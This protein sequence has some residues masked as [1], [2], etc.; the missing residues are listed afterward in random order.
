MNPSMNNI[1]IAGVLS[2]FIKDTHYQEAPGLGILAKKTDSVDEWR[3]LPRHEKETFLSEK[4]SW[5]NRQRD[6]IL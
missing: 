1:I 2:Y 4:E 3:I 6:F 5:F